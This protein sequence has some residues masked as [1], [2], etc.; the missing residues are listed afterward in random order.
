MA[1][2]C[3]RVFF[4]VWGGPC[5]GA[6]RP[7]PE[8][9]PLL[10]LRFESHSKKW[11]Q[12][13]WSWSDALPAYLQVRHS[14]VPFPCAPFPEEGG[15]GP[16]SVVV[17]MVSVRLFVVASAPLAFPF[18]RGLALVLVLPWG[19]FPTRIFLGPRL[20]L[21]LLRRAATTLVF[22]LGLWLLG[23][24][25]FLWLPALQRKAGLLHLEFLVKFQETLYELEDV[26]PRHF[27]LDGLDLEESA[28]E[29]PLIPPKQC[30]LGRLIGHLYNGRV[31]ISPDHLPG[32]PMLS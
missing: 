24:A 20:V 2:T 30:G 10:S 1:T 29:S 8:V 17:L 28:S 22:A 15:G 32:E 26:I 9:I 11:S 3:M 12:V 14:K 6:P 7:E 21:V 27:I 25:Y 4:S 31:G 19:S 16:G 23:S 13:R 5:E 18:G